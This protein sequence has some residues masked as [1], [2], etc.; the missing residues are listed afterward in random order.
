MPVDQ[1]LQ[2]FR[3]T[4]SSESFALQNPRLLKVELAEVTI[5]A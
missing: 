4:E 1:A 3:E 5:Q 2:E